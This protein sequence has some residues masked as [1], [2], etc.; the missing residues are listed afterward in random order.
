MPSKSHTRALAPAATE[1]HRRTSSHGHAGERCRCPPQ[2]RGRGGAPVGDQQGEAVEEHLQGTR[3]T[4]WRRQGL[5]AAADLLEDALSGEM[6]RH[7]RRTPGGQVGLAR[8]LQVERFEPAGRLEQQR[9][10]VAAQTRG[11]GDV[12]AQQ[13]SPGALELIQGTRPPPTP[14]APGPCRTHRPACWPAPRPAL[15]SACRAGSAVSNTDRCRNAAAAARPPRACAR[16]A[17]RSS[18]AATSSSG[19]SAAWARCQARRSG[20]ARGSVTSASAACIRCLSAAGAD[21]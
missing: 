10:C 11:E 12:A 20:S 6:P 9:G 15:R 3:S 17:E 7:A 4:R 18:S 2:R 21:R 1:P 5:G 8:E 19:P 16:P 13:V 14:A